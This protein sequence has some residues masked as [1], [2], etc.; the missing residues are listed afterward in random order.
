MTDDP[1][2]GRQTDDTS[3]RQRRLAQSFVR[4][5]QAEQLLALQAEANGGNLVAARRLDELLDPRRPSGPATRMA[6]GGYSAARDSAIAEGLVD[7]RGM[8]R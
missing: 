1:M 8:P 5:E 6:L 3:K 7:E 2:I 4:N